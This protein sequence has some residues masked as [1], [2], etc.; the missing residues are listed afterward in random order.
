MGGYRGGMGNY[1]M[2]NAVDIQISNTST[3]DVIIATEETHAPMLYGI[4]H[5]VSR[6]ANLMCN[7]S[8][9]AMLYCFTQ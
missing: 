5:K 3:T 1:N 2:S 4:Y 8:V 7:T 9:Y 6:S